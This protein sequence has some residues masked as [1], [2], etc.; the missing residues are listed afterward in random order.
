MGRKSKRFREI[1][2]LYD[3][4]KQYTLAEAVAILKK[5]P[6][7]KYD[8]SVDISLKL[9]VDP[10]KADQQVRNTV[11]LP[12]GTGKTVRVLVIA[13]GEKAQ[14][15]K[16]AGADFVGQD[17]LIEKIKGGWT[18][19]DVMIA[20]PDMM[21]EIGKLGKVLGPRGLMP[22]P[23]AGTVTNDVAKAIV[24]VKGGKIEFRADRNGVCN[25]MVG[26]VSFNDQSLVENLEAYLGALVRVK[27]SGVKGVYM[28]RC[29]LSTTM[30]PGIKIDL[31]QTKAVGGGV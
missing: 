30:G 28:Q 7:I 3:A 20:T 27:P 18:E 26:K 17:D 24:D 12:N 25:N 8:Q 11:A 31:R 23:K 15:A 5:C 6:P 29:S 10:R 22:T 13:T 1:V 19:F 21:R 2:K 16:A 4:E 9:N 14:E